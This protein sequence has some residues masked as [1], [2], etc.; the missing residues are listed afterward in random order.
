MELKNY[1]IKIGYWLLKYFNMQETTNY[2]Y[3]G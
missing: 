1:G 3:L 2:G